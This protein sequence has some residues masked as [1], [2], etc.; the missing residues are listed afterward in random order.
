MK[1]DGCKPLLELFDNNSDSSF[2][3]F[4][5]DPNESF[6]FVNETSKEDNSLY[7]KLFTELS[8][9]TESLNRLNC[10][11]S[12]DRSGNILLNCHE[13]EFKCNMQCHI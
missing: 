3:L 6:I 10:N 9:I 13:K 2:N 5:Y 12:I 1:K 11:Y 4:M 8:I 7:Q